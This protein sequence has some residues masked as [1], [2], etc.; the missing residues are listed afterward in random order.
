M[1]STVPEARD[2]CSNWPTF[3]RSEGKMANLQVDFGKFQLPNPVMTASGTFGYG[4][5]YANFYDISRLGAVVVKGIRMV[6]SDVNSSDVSVSVV[7]FP[8][9]FVSVSSPRQIG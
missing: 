3:T 7:F 5:E 4:M 2:R 9:Y 1:R 6:P 8:K